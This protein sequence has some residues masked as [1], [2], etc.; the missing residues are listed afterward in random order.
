MRISTH[1]SRLWARLLFGA[2]SL[3][4]VALV[5]CGNK[6]DLFLPVDPEVAQE[7]EDAAERLK[8]KDDEE[9]ATQ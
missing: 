1:F 2:F 7:L 8:K 3:S 9:E 4:L 6:G 5:G